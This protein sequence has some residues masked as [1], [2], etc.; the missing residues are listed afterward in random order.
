MEVSSAASPT[1]KA[2]RDTGAMYAASV[3]VADP[4]CAAAL[5]VREWRK[6]YPHVVEFVQFGANRC[7]LKDS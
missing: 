4:E 6:S 2:Q 7:G 5:Q 1:A 3:C